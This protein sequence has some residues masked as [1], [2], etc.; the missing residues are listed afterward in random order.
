[1]T[2][3]TGGT[4]RLLALPSLY[5][6]LQVA[7]GSNTSHERFVAEYVRPRPGDR[8]L[9]V[10]C[11]TGRVLRAFPPGVAYLGLD[12]SADYIRTA[13]E[14]WGD[15]GEFR[16]VDVREATIPDHAFDLVMTMGVLHH[17][18]DAGCVALV[19]LA[20]RSLTP[21]G[22]FVAIEPARVRGQGAV[23]RWLIGRDRG[24]HVRSPEQYAAV[25]ETAFRSV[26][27]TTRT[28][29][30]RVPYTHAVLEYAAPF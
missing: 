20:A 5:E 26:S 6:L 30:L 25:A 23:E 14:T 24:A 22:R 16:C 21:E 7:V 28:D 12:T 27:V 29:L 10:G 1:M 11:G 3:A 9:D 4:R 2:E 8:V 13:R 15:R 19:S 17:L 18:D